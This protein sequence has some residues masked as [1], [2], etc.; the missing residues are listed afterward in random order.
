LIL[1]PTRELA[2]Q[3]EESFRAY[4]RYTKVRYSLIIG[5]VAQGPQELALKQGVD[6]I[7]A[8]PGRLIDLIW[9]GATELSNI[10]VFVLDEADRMLDMGFIHDVRRVIEFLPKVRQTLFY[11]ATMPTEVRKLCDTILKDPVAVSVTPVSSTVDKIDQCVYLT[12]YTAKPDLLVWLLQDKA[13]TN[14]L[15]FTR[16]KH[17]ADRLAT[18]LSKECISAASIHGDKSQGARQTALQNFKNG[19][20]RV[21]VATDIA[22]RGIDIDDLSHVINYEL[23]HE[24]ETYV[25]RIGRTGRAGKTGIALSLCDYDEKPLLADIQKL[26]KKT[27]PV[28]TE[29]PH[30]M[31]VFAKRPKPVRQPR[32]R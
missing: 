19:R 3:I 16:T 21:L 15:I 31:S 5:G 28:I 8:T 9:Q 2:L 4:G 23:P 24:P 18:R 22:A 27:V 29:H 1:T 25:H 10:E 7:I 13:I 14:A 30:P 26:I 6:V 32:R 11:T 17:G 20:V 12:D